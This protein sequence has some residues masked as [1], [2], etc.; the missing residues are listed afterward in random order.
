MLLLTRFPLKIIS[1]YCKI[2]TFGSRIVTSCWAPGLRTQTIWTSP[3]SSSPSP[4]RKR[5]TRGSTWATSAWTAPGSSPHRRSARSSQNSTTAAPSPICTW[6]TGL[7]D[8]TRPYKKMSLLGSRFRELIILRMGLRF[9][10]WSRAKSSHTSGT[11]S[12][13]VP[14]LILSLNKSVC[15]LEAIKY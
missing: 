9:M 8:L 10:T 4:G 13:Q 1:V 7:A 15:K 3:P 5:K 11:R 14:G 2:N 6:T 12:L